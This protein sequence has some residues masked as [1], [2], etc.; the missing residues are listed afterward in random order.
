MADAEY[1]KVKELLDLCRDGKLYEIEAWIKAGKSIQMPPALQNSP[2]RIAIER[3]F[4]SLVEFLLRNGADPN[5]NGNALRFAIRHRKFGVVDLLL[6]NGARIH[7]VS[8]YTVCTSGDT[9][10]IRLFIERGADIVTGAPIARALFERDKAML[11]IVKEYLPKRPEIQAQVD[12]A[13]RSCCNEGRMRGVCLLLWLGANPRAKGHDLKCKRDCGLERSG[14]EE[15]IAGGH[16]EIIKKIGIDPKTDDLGNLMFEAAFSRNLDVVQ[17]LMKEGADLNSPLYGNQTFMEHSIWSLEGN[18][19][20]SFGASMTANSALA[21]IG[22]AAE[23]GAKWKPRDSHG[24]RPLRSI[25]Y[26]ASG[27]DIVEFVKKMKQHDAISE[28]DLAKLLD[29]P[30]FRQQTDYYTSRL[31]KLVPGF[32]KW[33]KRLPKELNTSSDGRKI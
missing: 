8:F 3:G 29:T 23:L 18:V 2:L 16:V 22:G 4:Y 25:L 6:R 10:L 20:S 19:C 11:G 21:E 17:L 31:S 14:L 28:A 12:M 32:K 30:K 26:R 33:V 24:F 1:Q 13:F 5:A 15:A 7:S 27:H 9:E